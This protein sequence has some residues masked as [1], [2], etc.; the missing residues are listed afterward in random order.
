MQKSGSS[1]K[2]EAAPVFFKYSRFSCNTLKNNDAKVVSAME[3]IPDSPG[4]IISES[5]LEGMNQYYSAELAQKA[6][7]NHTEK[8]QIKDNKRSHSF[9]SLSFAVLVH[10]ALY[11]TVG[12]KSRGTGGRRQGISQRR[13]AIKQVCRTMFALAG[14]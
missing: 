9:L 8:D 6:K 1:S 7:R 5:L 10:P 2:I 11:H 13:P 12:R 3:N 14:T 4:G